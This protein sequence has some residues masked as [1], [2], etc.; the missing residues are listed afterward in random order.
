MTV[1]TLAYIHNLLVENEKKFMAA[2]RL[3]RNVLN[4]AEKEGADNLESLQA[5]YDRAYKSWIEAAHVLAQFEE[6]DW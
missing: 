5:A 3:T 6:R 1:K 2:R 4:A